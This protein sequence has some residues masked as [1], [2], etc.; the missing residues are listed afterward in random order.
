M[1][2]L[3]ILRSK[4]ERRSPHSQN[5]VDLFSEWSGAFPE[6]LEISAGTLALYSDPRIAWAHEQS[7][8]FEGKSVLELGPL[9]GSHSYMIEKYGAQEVVAIEANKQAYLKCLISKEILRLE[10]CRFLLGDF[11]RYLEESDRTFD[12]IVA[13]GILYHLNDP[14]RILD[15]ICNRCETLVLWTHYFDST[16]MHASDLRR[17]P[18]AEQETLKDYNGRTYRLHRRSYQ[19]AWMAEGYCGGPED[20]HYWMERD[21][22]VALCKD[23]GFKDIRTEFEDAAHVNGPSCL[24]YMSKTE[25][26]SNE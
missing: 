6:N 23:N 26:S 9:E 22:I 12:V 24:F 18:F 4:Y 25:P 11:E 15:H 21:Q 7:N 16:A 1:P 5:A 10:K 20:D 19:Q 3:N 8:L 17:R 14:V 13:S 2:D